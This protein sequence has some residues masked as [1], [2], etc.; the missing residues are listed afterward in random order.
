MDLS[1]ATLLPL[2]CSF[3]EMGC[4]PAVFI[5]RGVRLWNRCL[6]AGEAFR[7]VDFLAFLL[8][9]LFHAVC[10]LDIRVGCCIIVETFKRSKTSVF[11][12]DCY[13]LK[14]NYTVAVSLMHSKVFVCVY[15][16]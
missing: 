3:G 2:M 13:I 14:D 16:I 1:I 4:R 5:L 11:C 12:L 7:L 9:S 15:L 10:A 8:Y 6:I